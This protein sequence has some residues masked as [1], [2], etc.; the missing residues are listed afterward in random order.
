MRLHVP[1]LM[2]LLRGDAL[3]IYVTGPK[4]VIEADILTNLLAFAAV[5]CCAARAM[6]ATDTAG[7]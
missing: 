2:M 3:L 4:D 1:S 7:C 5:W 6:T